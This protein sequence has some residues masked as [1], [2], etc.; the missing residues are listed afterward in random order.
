MDVLMGSKGGC[1]QNVTELIFG[2]NKAA[3]RKVNNG[4]VTDMETVIAESWKLMCTNTIAQSF[5]HVIPWLYGSL[6]L[7]FEYRD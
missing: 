5:K 6:E 3:Y 7:E 2:L 4:K 1:E